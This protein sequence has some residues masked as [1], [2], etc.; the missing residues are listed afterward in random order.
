M[1]GGGGG[2]GMEYIWHKTDVRVEWPPFPA[3]PGI[4]LGPFFI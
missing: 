1:T 4:W 3:L 2:L